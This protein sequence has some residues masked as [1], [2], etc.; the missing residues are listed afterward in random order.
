MKNYKQILEAIN[1]GIK[2]ALDDYQDI[3][4]NSSISQTNDIIDVKDPIKEIILRDFVDL[5]LPSG[6]L[7]AKYNLGVNPKKLDKYRYW[8]GE[9]YQWGETRPSFNPLINEVIRKSTA[10]TSKLLSSNEL[11]D[12]RY[13]E[14]DGLDELLPEDDPVFVQY[15]SINYHMPTVK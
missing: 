15:R 9:Y 5:G 2:L 4:P 11:Y 13:N 12:K 6:T 3:D 7:W 14:K 10:D 8:Y 1:R